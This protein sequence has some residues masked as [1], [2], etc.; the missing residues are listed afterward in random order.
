VIC[1]SLVRQ[2]EFAQ[3]VWVND[4]NF[5]ELGN[6][7]DPIIGSRRHLRFDDPEAP[8]PAKDKDKG[9]ACFHDRNW[10]C[11]L[12]PSG[13]R[14]ASLFGCCARLD[15]ASN[16]RTMVRWTSSFRA[17][18]RV[19][20]DHQTRCA[21][22]IRAFE[23]PR[24]S[25]RF[26]DRRYRDRSWRRTNRYVWD[27]STGYIASDDGGLSCAD[28]PPEGDR[29]FRLAAQHVRYGDRLRA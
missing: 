6:E 19:L 4:P 23:Q 28:Q 10:R 15:T 26:N 17:K 3:N 2:F 13:Y 7:R 21:C 8:D 11:L 22:S 20:S 25:L 1:A 29:A 14:G 16:T 9:P 27:T 12:L 5:H 24:P 18:R